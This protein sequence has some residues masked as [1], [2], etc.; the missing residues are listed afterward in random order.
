MKSLWLKVCGLRVKKHM[1]EKAAGEKSV[2]AKSEG[3]KC[4]GESI[5]VTSL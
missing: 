2:G 1:G 5:W 3:E 4:V